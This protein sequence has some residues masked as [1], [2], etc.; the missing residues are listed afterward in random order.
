[1]K[2]LIVLSIFQTLSLLAFTLVYLHKDK[3]TLLIQQASPSQIENRNSSPSY[4]DIPQAPQLTESQVRHIV[5]SELE[6]VVAALALKEKTLTDK[7]AVLSNSV[8][9]E[10]LA[11]RESVSQDIDYYIAN[12]VISPAEMNALQAKI[13]RLDE[14]GRK[15]MFGKLI[16]AMNSKQLDGQL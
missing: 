4:L 13:A 2:I 12:G 15:Q 6:S 7:E 3:P 9:T 1:M 5:K 10:V 16:S 8:P 11:V 14:T